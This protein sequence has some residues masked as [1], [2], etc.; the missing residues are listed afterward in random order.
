MLQ[1]HLPR[2]YCVAVSI[3]G[4]ISRQ[5]RQSVRAMGLKKP[6]L[7][8]T[9]DRQ[10]HFRLRLDNAGYPAETR[11]LL[12]GMMNISDMAAHALSAVVRYREDTKFALLQQQT[13]ASVA[14]DTGSSPH[15][16]V[17]TLEPTGTR[18]GYEYADMGNYVYESWL[19]RMRIRMD[20]A[21]RVVHVIECDKHTAT[22]TTG[23]TGPQHGER[24]TTIA[25]TVRYDTVGS[26]LLPVGFD[27]HLDGEPALSISAAYREYLSYLVFDS[28]KVCYRRNEGDGACLEMR[29]GQYQKG[30]TS[31]I[32]HSHTGSDS[33]SYNKKVARAGQLAHEAR[34]A[35][36]AGD[37]AKATRLLQRLTRYFPDTPQ[38]IEAQNILSALP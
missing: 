29:Y 32:Q 17:I 25:Y 2:S 13:S 1:P 11:D 10:R 38:G 24:H 19:T 33:R 20:T 12:S 8:E 22:R 15:V 9:M 26:A 7:V 30:E 34:N 14:A 21:S 37:I 31:C 27:V 4:D 16:C 28:K 5:L 6:R 35:M 23:M 18:F 3:R 36:D